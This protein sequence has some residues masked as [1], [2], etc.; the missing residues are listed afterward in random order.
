VE[1]RI[2]KKEEQY[3][4]TLAEVSRLAVSDPS[5]D[6]DDGARLEL[7]AKLV[8]DYERNQ[9]PIA[10]PTPIEA[11]VFRMEEQGLRQTDVAALFGSKSRASEVLSGKRPLTLPMI[12]NLHS[13]LAIPLELL[14][15]DTV[16]DPLESDVIDS[17]Q[18]P[19]ETLIDRGWLDA[20]AT[21]D[22]LLAK[23][24]SHMA[25]PVMLKNTKAFGA[26][27]RTNVTHVWLWLS[28]V[29]ELGDANSD[30]AKRYSK[31]S[32][33]DEFLHY[34]SRLSYMANGPRLAKEFLA[35]QGIS[36]II[37]P[38]L[39]KTHLDGAAMLS[40]QGTPII[41]M[42]LREDRLDNF[43]FTLIHE[44]VHAWKHLDAAERRTIVDENVEKYGDDDEM[45]REANHI[46]KETLIPSGVWRRSDAFL[47]PSPASIRALATELKIS[48]AIVAGR[49]R[50][51]TK[52]YS[53]FAK[54][55]G[56]R[57]S[58]ACFPELRWT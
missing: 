13:E 40:A 36:L 30:I 18:I 11:I 16:E 50:F 44:L 35:E 55:V 5:L 43:W 52:S 41:G 29:R 23:F 8:E 33:G 34:V 17:S 1:P 51:E 39:P 42:T 14:V 32:I 37:E 4:E 58:R 38:H 31:A 24:S 26:N 48:P 53:R 3:R 25:A 9:F 56:Y 6:S 21:V 45:E 46:A 22:D 57:Q 2:I 15:Q 54:L 49:Y 19:L 27:N 7:L 47:N 28:R 10:K 12:R 20:R